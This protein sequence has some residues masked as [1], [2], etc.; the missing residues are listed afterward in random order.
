[1]AEGFPAAA[2]PQCSP[3]RRPCLTETWAVCTPTLWLGS[4][5]LCVRCGEL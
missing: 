1:M 5:F 3:G 2:G 4:P